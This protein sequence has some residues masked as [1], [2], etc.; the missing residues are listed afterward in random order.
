[1][2]HGPTPDGGFFR[3]WLVSVRVE[4]IRLV[5]IEG[6]PSAGKS[7]LRDTLPGGAAWLEIDEIYRRSLGD[8][9]WLTTVLALGVVAEVEHLSKLHSLVIADGVE[10]WRALEGRVDLPTRRVYV[11]R[12]DSH[13]D[14]ADRL[15]L[16]DPEFTSTGLADAYRHHNDDAPWQRADL[17]I[18]RT[19][20]DDGRSTYQWILAPS[21]PTCDSKSCAS[22]SFAMKGAT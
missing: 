11:V 18:W 7:S 4:G 3:D 14:D 17:R 8:A 5:L 13:G 20:R 22:P 15:D 6:L 9:D 2:I 12:L 16:L 10:A 19:L 21:T 1:M